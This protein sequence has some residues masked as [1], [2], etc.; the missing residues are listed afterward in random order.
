MSRVDR[1]M[2][3]TPLPVLRLT[4][5]GSRRRRR[6][7]EPLRPTE[8]NSR[9][10]THTQVREAQTRRDRRWRWRRKSER[11]RR[12]RR[13][14]NHPATRAVR[15]HGRAAVAAVLGRRW[16][17]RRPSGREPGDCVWRDLVLGPKERGG[18]E[19]CRRFVMFGV[20]RYF[21]G[22]ALDTRFLGACMEYTLP[23]W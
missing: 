23:A 21:V 9:T 16:R 4:R 20:L 19:W 15:R 6:L 1:T 12:R 14:G 5:Q 8:P 18:C 2:G 22:W 7:P 13:G 11:Q 3:R 17:P 10:R